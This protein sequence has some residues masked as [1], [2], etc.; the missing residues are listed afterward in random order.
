MT[1]SL[2]NAGKDRARE[3]DASTLVPLV[4]TPGVPSSATDTDVATSRQ[5]DLDAGSGPHGGLEAAL[6]PRQRFGSVSTHSDGGDGYGERSHG[7]LCLPSAAVWLCVGGAG[8]SQQS[9]C[10]HGVVW[11]VNNVQTRGRTCPTMA[12]QMPRTL[13]STWTHRTRTGRWED[14]GKGGLAPHNTASHTTLRGNRHMCTRTHNYPHTH[15]R[16]QT[17]TVTPCCIPWVIAVAEAVSDQ[18]VDVL[19]ASPTAEEDVV[20]YGCRC[21]DVV[22]TPAV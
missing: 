16:A 17:D 19:H 13:T 9:I 3:V 10:V 5:T 2:P 11:L 22:Q 18:G 20:R 6:S 14:H 1:V 15:S 4:P 21:F 8:T 7:P 12:S